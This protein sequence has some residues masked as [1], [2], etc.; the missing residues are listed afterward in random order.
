VTLGGVAMIVLGAAGAATWLLTREPP[1]LTEE[2]EPND[3]P[4]HA[5]KIVAGSE[6]HGYLGKRSSPTEGDRDVFLVPWPSGS[7][8]VI[9]VRVTG[10]PNLDVNL[11]VSDGDGL[12]GA[13]GDQGGVGDGEVLHRRAVDGP[14]LVTVGQTIAPGQRLPVEN[15]SDPYTLTVTEENPEGGETEPNGTEADANPLTPT[16]ELRGYFDTR[17][18]VDFLRWAGGAGTFDVTVRADGLPLQWQLDDSKDQRAPGTARVALHAGS[19]LRLHRAD[20]L[21]ASRPTAERDAAWSV[22][23]TP[24]P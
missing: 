14:I 9:T 23:V 2:R 19:I 11:N 1:P 6:V 16:H 24:A 15:V 12:H 22:V 13:V 20:D 7:K 8:R 21:G 5:N 10:I 4:A 3:D 18:D 17:D